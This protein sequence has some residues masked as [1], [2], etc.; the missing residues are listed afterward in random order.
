METSLEVLTNPVETT[1]VVKSVSNRR[2]SALSTG[3]KTNAGKQVVGKNALKHGLLSKEIVITKGEGQED[4][5]EYKNLLSRLVDDLDPEGPLEEML[6]ERIAV[7]YWRLRRAVVAENGEIRKRRD[8]LGWEQAE[9]RM[10]DFD[11]HRQLAP[12]EDR[13]LFGERTKHAQEFILSK[14]Q[15]VRAVAEE[16][17]YLSDDQEKDLLQW[18][19]RRSEGFGFQSVFFSQIA[20]Q[21]MGAPSMLSD[22]NDGEHID[23]ARAK[24]VLLKHLKDGEKNIAALAEAFGKLEALEDEAEALSRSV[25]PSEGIDRILRYETSIERQMYRAM[26]QLERL[27]RQRKGEPVL[28]PINLDLSSNN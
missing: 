18:F 19:G 15:E 2:N 22:I 24:K 6:V 12:L 27:Q 10:K 14:V 25:P 7:C 11:R 3:P 23:P 17:G 20:K 16:V 8:A 28:P 4:P 13:G 1:P 9:R 26:N 21:A 5:N